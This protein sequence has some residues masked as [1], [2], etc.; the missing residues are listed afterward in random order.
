MDYV[1]DRQLAAGDLLGAA[2]RM[3]G[4]ATDEDGL[5]SPTLLFDGRVRAHRARAKGLDRL[6][7]VARERP[8]E[9]RVDADRPFPPLPYADSAVHT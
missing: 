6:G 3:V 9:N 8:V 1:C 5:S 2:H 7:D 4:V